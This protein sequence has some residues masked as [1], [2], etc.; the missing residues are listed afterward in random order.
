MSGITQHPSS[1]ARLVSLGTLSA[2]PS[3][4][5]PV[6]AAPRPSPGRQRT[7]GG[8]HL[9]APVASAVVSVGCQHPLQSTV[10]V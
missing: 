3:L 9:V 4:R 5:E 7:L 1:R 2:T 6:P 8:S 10:C